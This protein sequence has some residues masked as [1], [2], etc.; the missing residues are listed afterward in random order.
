MYFG[1][2][3]GHSICF[4][5]DIFQTRQFSLMDW[6]RWMEEKKKRKVGVEWWRR[7]YSLSYMFPNHA[8]S[9]NVHSA[10]GIL[11]VNR[12]SCSKA[13]IILSWGQRCIKWFFDQIYISSTLG[14]ALV[15][16]FRSKYKMFDFFF[17]KQN[18]KTSTISIF[19]KYYVC[20]LSSKV[21]PC[22]K[23]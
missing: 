2:D 10:N 6:K 5:V 21:P 13:S 18:L 19:L 20:T 15:Y 14:D 17:Q 1:E 12:T 4:F 8:S 7:F 11:H 23:L 3:D 16:S 9:W 22:F